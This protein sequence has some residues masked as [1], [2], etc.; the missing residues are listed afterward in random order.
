MRNP[1]PTVFALILGLF[2]AAP[3][4]AI[5]LSLENIASTLEKILEALAP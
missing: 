3:L 2:I 5:G 1:I 4:W